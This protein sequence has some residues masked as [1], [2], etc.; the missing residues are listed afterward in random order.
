[1]KLAPDPESLL[2]DTRRLTDLGYADDITLLAEKAEHLQKLLDCFSTYC[3]DNALIINPT[4]CEVVVFGGANAWKK[5]SW[6]VDGR[7]INRASQFKYL[8]V[9]LEGSKSIKATIKYRLGSMSRAQSCS[10]RALWRLKA[11][12]DPTLVA[13][14]FDIVARAAGD[15]GC[16]IWGTP[17]LDNWHLHDCALQRYHIS[18]L[19]R[20]LG[21]KVA[22]SSLATLFE[23]G[24]QP[25]QVGWLTRCCKYWNKLKLAASSHSLL[26]DA[27]QANIHFGLIGGCTN[28]ASELCKGLEF[29][30]P[31][32]PGDTWC[33]RLCAHTHID[34][35]KVKQAAESKFCSSFA[36]FDGLRKGASED[37]F[38]DSPP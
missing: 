11:H 24:K 32:E 25:M 35:H 9:V 38:T 5:H 14:M 6:V 13:D 1:M 22:T 27:I 31:L 20:S 19:K 26:K 29:A 4:K 7:P 2:P 18:I 23:H 28:W 17:W 30:S 37:M 12:K 34:I 33:Q 8:G 3:K 10:Y 15:Y 21:V 16:E 36:A